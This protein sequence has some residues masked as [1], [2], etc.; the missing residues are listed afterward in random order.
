MQSSANGGVQQSQ[1]VTMGPNGQMIS[2]GGA[3]KAKGNNNNMTSGVDEFGEDDG[4]GFGDSAAAPG[5]NSNNIQLMTGEDGQL[6]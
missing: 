5:G 2:M 4:F 3:K 1:Q 6:Q